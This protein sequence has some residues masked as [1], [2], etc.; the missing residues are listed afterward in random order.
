MLMS[1]HRHYINW[2]G[3]RETSGRFYWL[4]VPIIG[5]VISTAFMKIFV[6]LERFCDE[7][8]KNT[9]H[10]RRRKKDAI[11]TQGTFQL[12][13]IHQPR[14]IHFQPR[15]N[16]TPF[17]VI[18]VSVKIIGVVRYPI[19]FQ[20]VSFSIWWHTGGFSKPFSQVKFGTGTIF[21]FRERWCSRNF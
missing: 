8:A 12:F 9:F 13:R 16:K 4:F 14:F 7:R 19:T 20:N 5:G 3:S 15:V 6:F 2:Y 18:R 1:G 11:N 21:V 17:R 10:I